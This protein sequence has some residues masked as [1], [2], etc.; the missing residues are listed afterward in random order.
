MEATHGPSP[1]KCRS[2]LL[3]FTTSGIL[4]VRQHYEEDELEYLEC[5]VDVNADWLIWSKE[6]CRVTGNMEQA[7]CW[8]MCGICQPG[9]GVND[10]LDGDNGVVLSYGHNHTLD[11]SYK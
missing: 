11:V 4:T 2:G 6:G 9:G 5:V 8:A 3:D 7:D 1:C 10:C